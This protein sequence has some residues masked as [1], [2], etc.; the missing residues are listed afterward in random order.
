MSL[1]NLLINFHKTFLFSA[2]LD[3]TKFSNMEKGITIFSFGGL[4]LCTCQ[5]GF[6]I[7]SLGFWFGYF[8][9]KDKYSSTVLGTTSEYSF[10]ALLGFGYIYK[11][12]LSGEAYLNHCS[13]E[14]P[15]PLDLEIFSP[16]SSKNNS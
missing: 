16:F 1:W 5:T 12:K 7:L 15:L 4:P 9:I 6:V 3:P 13:I 2:L 10:F 8:S 11:A 14:I